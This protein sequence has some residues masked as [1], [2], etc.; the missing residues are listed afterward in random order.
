MQGRADSWP[1]QVEIEVPRAGFGMKLRAVEAWLAEWEIPYRI[2]SSLGST[3]QMRV[4]FAEEKFARAFQHYHGGRHVP[5]DEAAA[6]LA[7]DADDEALFDRLAADFG[8]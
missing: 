8:E 4:C 6:A 5:A 1:Y 7:A 2:G 3:G